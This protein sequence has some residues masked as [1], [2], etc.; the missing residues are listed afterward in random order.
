MEADWNENARIAFPGPAPN[1]P[2]TQVTTCAFDT[3]QDLLWTGN[4]YVSVL[5]DC[6][7]ITKQA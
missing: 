2:S 1:A 5:P 4:E 7:R 3:A 6:L